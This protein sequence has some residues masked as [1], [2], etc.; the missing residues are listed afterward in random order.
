MTTRTLRLSYEERG[1]LPAAGRAP[2]GYRGYGEVAVERL[3]FIGRARAAGLSLAQI[4]EIL[5]V[6]DHGHAPCGPGG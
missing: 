5:S 2:D 1:L 3:G 4:G 6:R